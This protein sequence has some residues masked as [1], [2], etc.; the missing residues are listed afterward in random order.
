M[1]DGLQGFIEEFCLSQEHAAMQGCLRISKIKSKVLEC[2]VL[3]MHLRSKGADL[4]WS[5]RKEE[6]HSKKAMVE[7]GRRGGETYDPLFPGINKTGTGFKESR[8]LPWTY[9]EKVEEVAEGT[10][11]FVSLGV[12]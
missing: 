8:L 5:Q 3:I 2:L 10:L 7:R 9:S 12:E 4:H 1:G 6:F 11:I